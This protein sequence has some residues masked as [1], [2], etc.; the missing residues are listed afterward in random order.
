MTRH[1]PTAIDAD[2]IATLTWDS[3]G[4]APNVFSN[5]TIAEFT[6]EIRGLLGNP[7]VKGIVITS[8]RRDFIV[9]ADLTMLLAAMKG[10]RA[11]MFEK[12]RSLQQLYRDVET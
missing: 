11:E 5:E 4:T 1:M 7:A 12:V 2:G 3:P 10:T 8:T 6:A 9:G